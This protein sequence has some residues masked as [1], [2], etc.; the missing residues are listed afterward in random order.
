MKFILT[1]LLF[2]VNTLAFSQKEI[3]SYGKVDIADLQ[4]KQCD[5]ETDAEAL[6]LLD[7]GDVEY[8]LVDNGF[9]MKMTKRTRIKIF[10]KKGFNQADV[11]LRYYAKDRLEQITDLSAKTYNLDASGKIVET[12]LEKSS[13]F[14]KKINRNYSELIFTMP[15]VKEGSIIEY[16]YNVYLES[17]SNLRDWYFQDRIPTRLS[18]YRILI[19]SYF[20][21][22]S[23]VYTNLPME[24]TKSVENILITGRGGRINAE[25]ERRV[26]KMK[27]IP[28]LKSEPYMSSYKDYLQRVEFQLSKIVYGDG[29]ERRIMATWPILV[30]QLMEDEDFGL[31]ITKNISKTPELND[32]LKKAT[33]AF[34]KMRAIYDYVQNKMNYNGNESI[35]CFDGVKSILDQKTGSSGD[36]NLLLINLLKHEGLDAFPLLVS[37]RE[38]GVVNEIL[39]FLYQFNSVMA[40]VEIDGTPYVLDASGKY[41]TIDLI[42]EDVM[43]TRGYV[44]DIMN[45]GFISL[46]NYKSVKNA[47]SLNAS[48]AEDGVMKGEAKVFSYDYARIP[49]V[50]KLAEDKNNFTDYFKKD[51]TAVKV[52]SFSVKN[53]EVD[54]LALEQSV[55]F[56]LPLNSSGEY[57]YFT[58]NLFSGMEQN[59][60]ISDKRISDID[61]GTTQKYI[62]HGNITLPDN[63]ILL[64]KPKDVLYLSK[65]STIGFERVSL[66]AGNILQSR[67][68]LTVNRPVYLV[69]QYPDVKEFYKKVYEVLDEQVVIQKKKL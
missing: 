28:S 41:N 38:N 64:E 59:P 54:S 19:P 53:V 21:F 61:F 25:A 11:K 66:L 47:V 26:M 33:G 62:V 65:D 37:T 29:N 42:P 40:Y 10:N 31:Q 7:Y 23:G 6:K 8:E 67:L 55:Y 4:M 14:N 44:V 35:Y 63:Y 57:K 1:L 5:F 27:N 3:P 45:G 52:D 36:I 17:I 43:N 58:L 18:Y 30:K 9:R 20:V 60:F 2:G 56:S 39:P 22:M 15:E 50:R 49:R 46:F 34:G 13:I 24:D 51:L 48:I 32:E 16:K 68:T 12:N 69:S